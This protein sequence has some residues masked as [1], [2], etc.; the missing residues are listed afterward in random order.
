MHK[1]RKSLLPDCKDK[2]NNLDDSIRTVNDYEEFKLKLP[3]CNTRSNELYNLGKR[4]W[5]VF[6]AQL[7][8]KCSN[9][10]AHLSSLHVIDDPIC[11]CNNGVEDCSSYFLQCNLYNAER[12][13]IRSEISDI[14]TVT[15]ETILFGDEK[16]SFLKTKA[17]SKLYTSI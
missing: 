3:N 11:I 5:N 4:K 6:H 17:F 9:L 10:N 15:L 14:I 16:M 2:W 12:L 7:R 1:F 13:E 8:T